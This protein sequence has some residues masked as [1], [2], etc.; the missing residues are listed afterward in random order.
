MIRVQFWGTR[1]SITTPG[2][3][4][5]RYGGNT[6][7]VEITH[8]ENL[9]PGTTIEAGSTHL[10]L[11]G[12]SALADQ[13]AVAMK[14]PCARGQGKVHFLLSHYHWDHLIGLPFYPPMF[15]PGNQVHFY[16]TSTT[17]LESS[18]QRLIHSVYAPV[19]QD[20]KADFHYHTAT[21][22]NLDIENFQVSTLRTNHASQTLSYRIKRD[23]NTVVYTPDHEI[24]NKEIDDQ[25]VEQ[26]QHADI[27][28]LNAHF[29]ENEKK[30]RQ[31]WGHSS[32]IEATELAIKAQVKTVALFHHNPDHD[33]TQLDQMHHEACAL[34]KGTDTTV[35]MTRDKM[36][37]D[38]DR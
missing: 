2:P 6:S 28:I 24:G 9:E 18:F 4:T 33:D 23:N 32:H 29:T 11:D 20:M 38:I 1:G 31:G 5:S 34:A 30:M 27:W 8:S 12:G 21:Q 7:C 22:N 16:G 25:L 13:Q 36:V 35:R 14:G 26:A 15:I 10:M 3:T 17:E 19:K 37:I